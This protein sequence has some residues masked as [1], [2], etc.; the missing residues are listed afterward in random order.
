MHQESKSDLS[1]VS[2]EL[3]KLTM[4]D[5]PVPSEVTAKVEALRAEGKHVK[6]TIPRA[7]YLRLM[8]LPHAERLDYALKVMAEQEAALTQ[9][10]VNNRR[11]AEQR[12]LKRRASKRK[13]LQ[14][15][16]QRAK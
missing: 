13:R 1:P 6:A 12:R 16:K 5:T 7:D 3:P 2:L 10:A 4:D 8:T 14:R 9:K 11:I 15:R